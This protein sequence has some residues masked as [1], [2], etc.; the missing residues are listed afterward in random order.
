VQLPTAAY[1]LAL[2][3]RTNSSSSDLPLLSFPILIQIVARLSFGRSFHDFDF[4]CGQGVKVIDQLRHLKTFQLP[5]SEP[6]CANARASRVCRAGGCKG[7]QASFAMFF[8]STWVTWNQVN[9]L[10]CGINWD[11]LGSE[12]KSLRVR[13]RRERLKVR[14]RGASAELHPQS[15]VRCVRLTRFQKCHFS[16]TPSSFNKVSQLR[17]KRSVFEFTPAFHFRRVNP[18]A[19]DTLHLSLHHTGSQ[20]GCRDWIDSF[21]DKVINADCF[22]QNSPLKVLV[23]MAGGKALNSAAAPNPKAGMPNQAWGKCHDSRTLSSENSATALWRCASW[24]GITLFL[25]AMWS[26]W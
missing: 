18:N 21:G 20:F 2:R 26:T 4:L 6:A 10:G 16:R 25:F 8:R 5:V 23:K 9:L 1:I 14:R 11:A 15:K 12:R 13:C 7:A 19:T 3:K 24:S 22:A 17:I